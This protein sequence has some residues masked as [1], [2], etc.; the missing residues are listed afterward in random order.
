MDIYKLESLLEFGLVKS[1]CD[2]FI[3][4]ATLIEANKNALMVT[5]EEEY[6]DTMFGSKVSTST[7]LKKG[8]NRSK[9]P[10]SIFSGYGFKYKDL[11]L[12]QDILIMVSGKSFEIL[13]QDYFDPNTI[14][15]NKHIRKNPE[16]IKED[17]ENFIV[18]VTGL[19]FNLIINQL[20]ELSE[21]LPDT[22]TLINLYFEN[23]ILKRFLKGGV[24]E[25]NF[26]KEKGP[27]EMISKLIKNKKPLKRSDLGSSNI[28]WPRTKK[29]INERAVSRLKLEPLDELIKNNHGYHLNRDRYNIIY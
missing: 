3:K 26:T 16:E 14:N 29:D 11:R 28:N 15:H 27:I 1:D 17:T 25:C 10:I 7:T 9:I 22:N 6:T 2:N 8:I 20:N 12:L 18:S 21:K 24:L 4:I 13:N 23:G 19:D 5:V